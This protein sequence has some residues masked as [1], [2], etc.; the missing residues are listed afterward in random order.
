MTTKTPDDGARLERAV[1]RNAEVYRDDPGLRV[2]ANQS[3]LRVIAGQDTLGDAGAGYSDAAT[4]LAHAEA[5]LVGALA[6]FDG[7]LQ[8]LAD[9]TGLT[10]DAVSGVLHRDK[11]TV[12]SKPGCVQCDA[13]ARALTKKGV[14]LV[15]VDVSD[16][17]EALELARGLGYLQVPVVV[18]PDGEHWSG[19]RPDRI[20]DLPDPEP[21]SALTAVVGPRL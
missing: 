10:V 15:K 17:A 6:A 3:S 18:T 12:L 8:S 16:D 21:P 13:T 19:F 5:R 11:L 4:R 14:A 9:A 20:A 2:L 1:G 7:T